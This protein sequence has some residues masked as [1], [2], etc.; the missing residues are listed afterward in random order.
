MSLEHRGRVP[1]LDFMRLGAGGRPD[2]EAIF[3]PAKVGRRISKAEPPEMALVRTLRL[4]LDEEDILPA[5]HAASMQEFAQRLMAGMPG[6]VQKS[7]AIAEV[8]KS[9]APTSLE[10]LSERL[11]AQA[12][13]FGGDAWHDAV[14]FS[15]GDF[16]R[17]L[18]VMARLEAAGFPR[19]EHEAV[20]LLQNM[21]AS[22]VW[23]WCMHAFRVLTQQPDGVNAE[24]QDA[25]R[26]ILVQSGRHAFVCLRT[27][28]IVAAEAGAQPDEDTAPPV[29]LDAEE[30]ALEQ[31]AENES[32]VLLAVVE[33]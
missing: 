17:S 30:I 26:A 13:D 9:M 6:L 1:D 4:R 29:E 16:Q 11:A 10:G 31:D 5:L 8:S 24:I 15:T 27:V 23:A 7:F 14:Y 2:P 20:A 12:L 3:A 32:R 21:G 19:S 22:A 18:R 33:Q 28:E 25:V